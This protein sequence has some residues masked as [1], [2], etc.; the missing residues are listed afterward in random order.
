M[1]FKIKRIMIVALY[2]LLGMTNQLIPQQLHF[3]YGAIIGVL[4]GNR[5]LDKIVGIEKR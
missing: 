5:T 4:I 3:M 2:F 1:E